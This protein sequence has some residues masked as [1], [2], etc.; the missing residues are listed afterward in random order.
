MTKREQ[1]S[2]SEIKKFR[3]QKLDTLL[4]QGVNPY[5]AAFNVKKIHEI[6]EARKAIGKRVNVVGR[7]WAIRRHGG[8]AFADL[9]RNDESIQLFLQ[10]E[11]L[12]KKFDIVNSLDRGDFI[13]V[14]GNIFKTKTEEITIN[15]TDIVLLVKSLRPLPEK[16]GGLKNIETRYRQRYL[17]LL[18]HPE[19]KKIFETRAKIITYARNYL[20]A[21]GFL[22]VETPTLQQVY[23]GA[24]ARPF[25]THHNA[26][27]TD[28]YLRISDELYLKRLIVGGFN[29]VY[30]IGKDFRNEG[31]DKQHNP[32]FTMLEFYWAYSTYEQLMDFT[33]KMVVALVKKIKGSH[34]IDYQGKTIDFSPPWKRATFRDLLLKD[35]SIDVDTITTEK[36]LISL[37]KKNKIKLDLTN[38]VGY[39]AILDELYKKISK[40]QLQGPMFVTNHPRELLPLAK[41]HEQDTN[42]VASF[43]LVIA[44]S[45]IVKAYN[46]LNNPLEQKKRWEKEARRAKRGGTEYQIFDED[47]IT[48]LEYGMPP[49]AGWGFGIDR[50]TM[51]VTNS[52]NI[53]DVILFPTLKPNKW[54]KTVSN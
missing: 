47:Y 41:E 14:T 22:E 31:I 38:I 51:L 7:V 5:P 54:G 26:L 19:V 52:A 42:K 28:L 35:T 24:T 34:K 2:L 40:P 15:A 9:K 29:K 27:N 23:G 45:E 46:E 30:E 53:R 21:E 10:K 4:Q 33:E 6:N 11:R 12:V 13:G 1:K 44:G 36:E 43:N 50:F 16:R 3:R 25:I 48:A 37:L 20:D 17:D 8:S 18:V 49:T 32:E 39:A